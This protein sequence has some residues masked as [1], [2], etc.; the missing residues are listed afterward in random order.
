MSLSV[1]S[2]MSA[3]SIGVCHRGNVGSFCYVCSVCMSM[4]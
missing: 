4:S 1:M 2:A 3:V